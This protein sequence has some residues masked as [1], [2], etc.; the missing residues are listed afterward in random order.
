MY[1]IEQIIS[2]IDY[3]NPIA[4]TTSKILEIAENPE[5]SIYDMVELI[6]YDQT[7]TANI[8]KICNSAYFGLP[9]KIE[10]L[11]QAVAYLGKNQIAELAFM[12]SMA[13]NLRNS[14]KGYCLYEGEL[15]KYSVS[16]AL[17]AKDLA[18]RK[19]IKK[20]RTL[21]FTA[22]LLKDIG[23]VILDR[24]VAEGFKQIIAKVLVKGCSFTEAE[25][26]VLGIDHTELGGLVAE[27]W[28]FSD[29]MINIIRHHHKPEKEDNNNSETSIVYLADILCMMIGKGCG[30]DGLSY[31]LYREATDSLHFSENDLMEVMLGFVEEFQKVDEFIR[32]VALN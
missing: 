24:Y 3:L 26:Q 12:K 31:R 2:E 27:K 4:G 20:Q 6:K 28:N 1:E 5:S 9:K 13:R 18:K 25:K 23:K 11:D 7:M 30:A 10:S 21:I 22:A 8:L 17:L 15:W 29:K 14:Q 16:S 19:G 32:I